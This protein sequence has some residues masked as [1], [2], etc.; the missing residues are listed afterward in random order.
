[1]GNQTIEYRHGDLKKVVTHVIKAN[2]TS[3]ARI[4]FDVVVQVNAKPWA[5]VFIDGSTRQP[6]GQTPLSEVLVPIGGVLVFENPNFPGKT[7]RVKGTE[8]EIRVTFP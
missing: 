4:T 8:T 2:E 6:L 7:Y 3:T 1:M 5:Q